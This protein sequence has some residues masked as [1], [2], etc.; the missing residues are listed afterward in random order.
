[1][2]VDP[3]PCT[4]HSLNCSWITV[5]HCHRRHVKYRV[6]R[7]LSCM[8]RVSIL[9]G[10]RSPETEIPCIDILGS[11]FA[12]NTFSKCLYFH[13]L[14]TLC[15][16]HYVASCLNMHD[17][18]QWLTNTLLGQQKSAASQQAALAV[19]IAP[20]TQKHLLSH[21]TSSDACR[22]FSRSQLLSSAE[23]LQINHLTEFSSRFILSC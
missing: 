21:S 9:I 13:L 17:N 11:I 18:I 16:W 6:P 3:A 5:V 14:M 19:G 15:A 1:M 20:S 2:L 8:Y 7:E 23:K 4:L 12:L 22:L 10:K